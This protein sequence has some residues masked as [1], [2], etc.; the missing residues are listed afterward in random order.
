MRLRAAAAMEWL[1]YGS[2]ALLPLACWPNLDH[3]FESPKLWLLAVVNVAL[4]ARYLLARPKLDRPSGTSDWLWL[5][6]LAAIAVSALAAPYVSLGAMLL[7]AAPIALSFALERG[8]ISRERVCRAIL[9]GS[10]AMCAVAVLQYAGA[11]PLRWLGWEPESFSSLR[12]RVYGTLGNPNFVA[13]WCAG[14]L[15]LAVTRAAMRRSGGRRAAFVSWGVAALHLGAILATGSRVLLLAIPVAIAAMAVSRGAKLSR[16]WLAAA[17]LVL[18]AAVWLSPGRP[19]GVVLDGRLYLARVA[20]SGWRNIPVVGH[21]PGSFEVQLAKQQTAWLRAHP[22]EGTAF[23]GAVDHAHNDYLEML[24]EL[25]PLGLG[26]FVALAGVFIWR[27]RRAPD[28]AVVLGALGG[29]AALAAVALA[30]FPF[31]RPAEWTLLLTLLGVAGQSKISQSSFNGII[32][33]NKSS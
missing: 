32:G 6:W 12:M 30:D 26:T 29:A 17:G 19:L 33:G 10:S 27:A 7:L 1:V 24:I 18:L 22:G 8:M 2:I 23:A 9:A 14:V 5:A 15:P 21:G 4:V 13:A 25:G 11:D 3:P 20:W 16:W 31:H 28:D